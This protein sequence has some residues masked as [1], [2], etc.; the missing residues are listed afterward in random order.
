MGLCQPTKLAAYSLETIIY[1]LCYC[2]QSWRS[3]NRY[4]A[5]SWIHNSGCNVV[6][7]NPA[8]ERK[9]S[10]DG[11]QLHYDKSNGFQNGTDSLLGDCFRF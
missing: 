10:K 4:G 6:Q 3:R 7:D 5:A 8:L 11:Q 2:I 1:L 9:F